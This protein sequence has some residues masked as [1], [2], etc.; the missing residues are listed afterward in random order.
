M[1]TM[2]NVV[3]LLLAGARCN[4]AFVLKYSLPGVCASIYLTTA[5][6]VRYLIQENES[7]Q[8]LCT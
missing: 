7:E 4:G 6:Q 8:G 3:V 2:I 5:Q 1:V